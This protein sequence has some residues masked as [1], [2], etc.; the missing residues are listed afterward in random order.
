MSSLLEPLSRSLTS[1]PGWSGSSSPTPLASQNST[2]AFR[3]R[4]ASQQMSY[5]RRDLGSPLHQRGVVRP[6]TGLPI[7]EELVFPV[8]PFRSGSITESRRDETHTNQRA[9]TG[10]SG[11]P[12]YDR[13]GARPG[14]TRYP[15]KGRRRRSPRTTGLRRL[16]RP[17]WAFASQKGN[18]PGYSGTGPY[19]KSLANEANRPD[20]FHM[21]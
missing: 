9:A 19:P 18:Q 7:V 3:S 2:G 4:R 11:A 12:A 17:G 1:W 20:Y 13:R 10:G 15:V 8:C 16:P 14:L 6:G 5:G 21:F